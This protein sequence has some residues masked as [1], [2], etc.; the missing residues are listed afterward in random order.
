MKFVIPEQNLAD[1]KL[2]LINFECDSRAVDT[3][4]T[5]D[6]LEQCILVKD[7]IDV[8]LFKKIYQKKDEKSYWISHY[9]WR[10]SASPNRCGY[11]GENGCNISLIVTSGYGK[12]AIYGPKSDCR[13]FTDISKRTDNKL[14][15]SYPC[16][17][18]PVICEQ[19]DTCYWSYNLVEH[20]RKS[21]PCLECPEQIPPEER[22]FILSKKL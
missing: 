10:L 1:I 7:M 17:N 12:N 6:I 18:R 22:T 4:Y 13:Y 2:F 19:C 14:V 5:S 11:C 9:S 21:H 8:T 16:S 15:K 3:P 20:Y